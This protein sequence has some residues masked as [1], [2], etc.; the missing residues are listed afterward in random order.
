LHRPDRAGQVTPDWLSP[1]A[2]QGQA[3]AFRVSHGDAAGRIHFPNGDPPQS[4]GDAM[5]ASGKKFQPFSPV[6]RLSAR[7][8]SL[9]RGLHPFLR[10]HGIAPGHRKCLCAAEHSVLPAMNPC[11]RPTI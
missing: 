8:G 5:C 4:I 7:L 10:S 3:A 2:Q 9:G 1:A 6:G 11:F